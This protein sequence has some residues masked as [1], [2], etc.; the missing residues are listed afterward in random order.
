VELA[1]PEVSKTTIALGDTEKDRL[2]EGPVVEPRMGSE[3]ALPSS[4]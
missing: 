2:E 4:E 1:V 3:S